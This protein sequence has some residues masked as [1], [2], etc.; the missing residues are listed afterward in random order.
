MIPG[1]APNI[2]LAAVGL[3]IATFS[4]QVIFITN[5][6]MIQRDIPNRDIGKVYSFR[7]ATTY[8]GLGAGLLLASYLYAKGDASKVMPGAA[9]IYLV[10]GISGILRFYRKER[11]N[12]ENVTNREN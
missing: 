3:T 5:V 1:L 12:Q 10:M 6:T 11:P 7:T 8:V 9:T 2:V 4:E